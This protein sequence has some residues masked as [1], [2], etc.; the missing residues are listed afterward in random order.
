MI[1]R[2][3]VRA[4]QALLTAWLGLLLL[5]SGCWSPAP[6]EVVVYSALDREFSESILQ[7]FE[8]E[9]GI[10][11]LAKYDIESTKTV[12]LVNEIL[13]ERRRPRCDL[14][15]N[16]EILHTLR[17]QRLGRLD[18]YVSPA[19]RDFPAAYRS[20]QG[21]WHGFAAR[22]RVLIVNT[23][24][25]PR[26]QRPSSIQDLVDPKWRGRVGIAKPLFGTTATQAAVLFSHWGRERAE[27]FFRQLKDNAQVLSG[28]KQV[29]VSVAQGQLAFGLTDTDDA[30]VERDQAADVELVFPDQGEDGLGALFIPNTLA[31]IQGAAH[32]EAARRLVDYL[33]GPAVE[34]QLAQGASAQFPLSQAVQVPSRAAPGQPIKR[35]P[36]DFAA[37]ADQWETAAAFLRDLFTD[38]SVH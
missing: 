8:A 27:A 32:P 31:L 13:Q 25:V 15:W 16:N 21:D 2:E 29:A 33:L 36:V 14:F 34:T 3:P 1:R 4:K 30:I 23:R 26:E 38:E 6:Q 5:T 20:P 22:V 11:V 18:A 9:T 37:A 7:A 24:L 12:G 28:N 10:K 35:M 17:L 19:A